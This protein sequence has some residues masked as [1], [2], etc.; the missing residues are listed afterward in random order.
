VRSSSATSPGKEYAT[1]RPGRVCFYAGHDPAVGRQFAWIDRCVRERLA[2]FDSKRR[3][4]RG[5]RWGQVHTTAWSAR[6]GIFALYIQSEA[7]QDP[8]SRTVV[9]VAL[10][11]GSRLVGQ[12]QSVPYTVELLIGVRVLR[13]A[14]L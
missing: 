13:E 4:K 14:E 11:S 2:L 9:G 8:G 5:R 1:P 6:L 12:S 10:A 3:Q 7:R